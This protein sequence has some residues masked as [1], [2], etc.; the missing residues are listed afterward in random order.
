MVQRLTQLKQLLGQVKLQ[1]LA[2]VE[3]KNRSGLQLKGIEHQFGFMFPPAV[4]GRFPHTGP[5]RNLL[6]G[7]MAIVILCQR[8]DYGI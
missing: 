8:L 4:D 7:Q 3:F 2:K 1:R 5:R 6:N